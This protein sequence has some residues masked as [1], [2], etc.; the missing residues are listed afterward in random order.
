MATENM[1]NLNSII[2]T[3]ETKQLNCQFKLILLFIIK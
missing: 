3:K 1:V 2:I